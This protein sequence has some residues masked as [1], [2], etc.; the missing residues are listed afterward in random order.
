MNRRWPMANWLSL[1]YA[2]RLHPLLVGVGFFGE[3]GDCADVSNG[4]GT[5]GSEP[6]VQLCARDC[7]PTPVI[8]NGRA[9]GLS[10]E[11]LAQIVPFGPSA[12]ERSFR[13]K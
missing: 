2:R 9:T 12:C 4:K 3:G 6:R 11:Q 13:R 5:S 8:R 7:S 1:A 10:H